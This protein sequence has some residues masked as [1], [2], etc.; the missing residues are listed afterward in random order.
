[1]VLTIKLITGLY[2]TCP[3]RLSKVKQML[4][5]QRRK[6]LSIKY[7]I[8]MSLIPNIFKYTF[9]RRFKDLYYKKSSL[10]PPFYIRINKFLGSIPKTPIMECKQK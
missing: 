2:R 5:Q 4:P 1:M 8:K 9:N 10:P 7:A 6:Y 3:N